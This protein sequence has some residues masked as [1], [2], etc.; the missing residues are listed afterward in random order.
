MKSNMAA[1]LK[2]DIGAFDSLIREW[3]PAYTWLV[4]S[5]ISGKTDNILNILQAR[6]S[7]TIGEVAPH[8]QSCRLQTGILFACSEAVRAN[9]HFRQT[10]SDLAEGC[11]EVSGYAHRLACQS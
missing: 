1:H 11:I 7:L 2:P 5:V 6:A 4:R 10:L 3:L 8:Q 9:D